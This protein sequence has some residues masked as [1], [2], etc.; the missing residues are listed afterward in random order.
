MKPIIRRCISCRLTYEKSQ[1]IRITKDHQLGVM[2][3]KGMGRS[4]YVCKKE[5]CFNHS[6]IKKKLQKSLKM[7]IEQALFENIEKEIEN[8]KTLSQKGI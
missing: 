4:A 6:Q 3:N 5:E 2:I 8:Y 7:K 1:L